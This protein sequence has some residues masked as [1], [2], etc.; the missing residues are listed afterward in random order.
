M[1]ASSKKPQGKWDAKDHAYEYPT[2]QPGTHW[3]AK[4]K[5]WEGPPQKGP[6]PVASSKSSMKDA[7]KAALLKR[8]QKKK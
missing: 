2:K 5:A 6:S 1:A 3:D 8:I 4:D 7:K